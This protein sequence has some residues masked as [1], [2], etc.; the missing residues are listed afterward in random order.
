MGYGIGV[1]LA[2]REESR[3]ETLRALKHARA[4]TAAIAA[5]ELTSGSILRYEPP[6]IA[7]RGFASLVVESVVADDSGKLTVKCSEYTINVTIIDSAAD[8]MEFNLS[9]ELTDIEVPWTQ[10]FDPEEAVT[11]EIPDAAHG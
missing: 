7:G 4:K 5:Q 9:G 6:E 8:P 1:D 10:S 2:E 3:R 11:I